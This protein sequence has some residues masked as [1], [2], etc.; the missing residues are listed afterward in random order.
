MGIPD[1][2]CKP[3]PG[4]FRQSSGRHALAETYIIVD[5]KKEIRLEKYSSWGI[6]TDVKTTKNKF[7]VL[8][9]DLHELQ[10]IFSGSGA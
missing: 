8:P 7:V 6:V 3:K 2:A 5:I 1:I 9:D 10:T 4:K